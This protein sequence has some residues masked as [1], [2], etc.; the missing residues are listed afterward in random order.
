MVLS[1]TDAPGSEKKPSGR[2]P[3]QEKPQKKLLQMDSQFIEER[4]SR[5]TSHP[6][7]PSDRSQCDYVSIWAKGKTARTQRVPSASPWKKSG[8][9]Q[10]AFPHKRQTPAVRLTGW[11]EVPHWKRLIKECTS[12]SSESTKAGWRRRGACTPWL[13]HGENQL[14]AKKW[15]GAA[16]KPPGFKRKKSAGKKTPWPSEHNQ[17]S[18]AGGG[19]GADDGRKRRLAGA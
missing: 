17:A 2:R 7:A 10:E 13:S 6:L 1:S 11:H 15:W 18:I 3:K 19:S 4:R 9:S 8:A 5:H 12:Q 16:G 14:S